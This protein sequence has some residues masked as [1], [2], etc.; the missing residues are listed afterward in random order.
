MNMAPRLFSF[1]PATFSLFSVVAQTAVD[2]CFSKSVT[3]QL[4]AST[5]AVYYDNFLSSTPSDPSL[6][7]CTPQLNLLAARKM[8]LG[9]AICLLI[10]TS[11]ILS[12]TSYPYSYT[13]PYSSAFRLSTVSHNQSILIPSL[14]FIINSS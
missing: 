2:E 9:L 14:S 1:S 13:F 11:S 6:R 10:S 3:S 5:K 8:C 4:T 7:L 12:S